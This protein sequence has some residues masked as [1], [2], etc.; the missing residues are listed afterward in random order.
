ME[1]SIIVYNYEYQS[2]QV[3]SNQICI[4]MNGYSRGKH[5]WTN[6]KWVA[7]HVNMNIC[8]RKNWIVFNLQPNDDQADGM[9]PFFSSYSG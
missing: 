5:D 1:Y 8:K 6:K 4:H 9:R 7:I 3:K 2:S